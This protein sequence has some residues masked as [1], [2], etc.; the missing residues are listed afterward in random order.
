VPTFLQ[1]RQQLA[2]LKYPAFVDVWWAA[3]RGRFIVR[4]LL[5]YW[6]NSDQILKGSALEIN[7]HT[8][9]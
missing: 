1:C 4:Q 5:A 8:Q 3:F 7:P 2:P 6:N 9:D